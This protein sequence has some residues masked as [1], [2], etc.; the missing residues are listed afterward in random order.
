[1]DRSPADASAL[2]PS[3]IA[4]AGPKLGCLLGTDPNKLLHEKSVNLLVI[5]VNGFLLTNENMI[6]CS[7]DY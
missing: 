3:Q 1:L 7:A 4:W 2:H 6:P 5:L